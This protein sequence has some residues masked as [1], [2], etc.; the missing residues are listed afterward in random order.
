MNI[1]EICITF[2]AG[3]LG[4]AYPILLEVVSRLDEKYSSLRVTDLFNQEREYKLFSFFLISSLAGVFMYM[5]INLPFMPLFIGGKYV[6]LIL[7]SL[8]ILSTFFLIISFLLFVKKVLLYYSTYRLLN[9]LNRNEEDSEEHKF[10]QATV[11]ILNLSIKKQDTI[12]AKTASDFIYKKFKRYRLNTAGHPV[13]YP[14]VFYQSTYDII[15]ELIFTG[16]ERFTYLEHRTIGGTW[17]LGDHERSEISETTFRWMW[18]GLVLATKHNRDDM[19]MEYWGVTHQHFIYELPRVDQVWAFDG[20]VRKVKNEDE[21]DKRMVERERL[22]EFNQ[23]LGGLMLYLSRFKVIRR[24]FRYTTSIPFTYELLPLTMDEV[25][26]IYFKFRNPYNDFINDRYYF[27]GVEGIH[28]EGVVSNWI[29]KYAALLFLRQYTII[30]YLTYMTPLKMPN[31]PT[32]QSDKRMWIENL[33]NFKIMVLDLFADRLFMEEVGFGY[34]TI[35]HI[36]EEGKTPPATFFDNLK[37]EL[38]DA[39]EDVEVN[40]Q[41]SADKKL[42]FL[43]TSAEIISNGIEP[44]RRAFEKTFEQ[45]GEKWFV[46]SGRMLLEKNAFS[47]NTDTHYDN[48]SGA[49]ATKMIDN[50][51]N[52]ISEIFY[53]KSTKS[54]L[55]KRTEFYE[56]IDRLALDTALYVIIN[57]GVDLEYEL[58]VHKIPGL[59]TTEYKGIE[60]RSFQNYRT[61]LFNPTFFIVAKSDLPALVF[62][63][64]EQKEVDK[65]DLEPIDQHGFIQASIIDLNKNQ[66]VR[67]ELGIGGD[68]KNLKKSV[69]AYIGMNIEI[70]C[71]KTIKMVALE[72]YSEYNESAA[73]NELA[74]VTMDWTP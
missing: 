6:A 66:Q 32:K 74:N 58:G 25:F 21:V 64:I 52:S 36:I 72:R 34:L 35:D 73:P 28:G 22:L 62:K 61:D 63:M 53:R 14:N 19:I 65:Y 39:F 8:L 5:L 49:L 38:A 26:S 13:L 70:H 3:I 60:V 24:M 16:N 45:P 71:E 48:F 57:F 44:Y 59:T 23:A 43:T 31:I 10:F 51:Y 2:I 9:Y 54:F 15:R 20:K 50:F 46:G 40:Q 68:N 42:E 1:P 67:D 18:R 30:P 11:D 56:A 29:C 47:D 27:P 7:V 4:V 12:A 33:D 17:L 55:I 37:K 69:L 41:I